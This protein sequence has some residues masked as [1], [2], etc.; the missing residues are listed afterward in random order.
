MAHNVLLS[1]AFS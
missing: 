1:L